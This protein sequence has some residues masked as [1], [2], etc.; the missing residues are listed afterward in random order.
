MDIE[1]E[2]NRN[3]ILYEDGR[4]WVSLDEGGSTGGCVEVIEDDNFEHICLLNLNNFE[5]HTN[6]IFLH[7]DKVYTSS[8]AGLVGIDREKRKFFHYPL[9]AK[10]REMR[11]YGAR[12]EGGLIW[13]VRDDGFVSIDL[14]NGEYTLYSLKNET[15]EIYGL[16]EFND[17][18][19]IS[20][21]EKLFRI[22]KKDLLN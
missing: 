22:A 14:A 5:I 19:Y 3:A 4:I 15:N 11:L 1:I 2:F 7:N 12:S 6:E 16:L 20:N 21:A 18:L 13:G 10:P 9:G 17:S 8:L